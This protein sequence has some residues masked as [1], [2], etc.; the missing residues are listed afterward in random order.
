MDSVLY[1][2]DFDF[3]LVDAFDFEAAAD[4]FYQAPFSEADTDGTVD[5]S[6]Q[7]V[8]EPATVL[9]LIALATV[10]ATVQRQKQAA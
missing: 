5:V 9:G 6:A 3:L 4:P 1:S 8:P 2:I 10:G 7:P